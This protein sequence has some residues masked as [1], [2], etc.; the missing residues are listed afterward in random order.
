MTQN[1]HAALNRLNPRWWDHSRHVLVRLRAGIAMLLDQ[2][3]LTRAGQRI[4]DVGCG[5]CP[6]RALFERAGSQYIGC[7]IGDEA[8]V[9]IRPGERIDL[10]DE[11]ADGVVSFQVLEHVWDIDWYLGEC[12]R[13]LKP[14]AWLLLTTHGNW[15][16]H[17]H[18][19]DYRRWTRDGLA[20]ELTVRGFE[21]GAIRGVVGPL[22]WATFLRLYGAEY[23]LKQVP[24]LGA[25]A[26]GAL[27]V[28]MNARMVL[29]DAI[30][31]AASRERNACVYVTLSTRTSR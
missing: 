18:P 6:Y 30:T 15:P 19:T 4:V 20:Q 10:P 2:Y 5:T 29:E 22:A 28:I 16:Y 21:V 31:P 13:L 1:D 27:A 11:S 8:D 24:A 23:I 25:F 14:G 12:R 26:F 9:S 3:E 7:D 17:P